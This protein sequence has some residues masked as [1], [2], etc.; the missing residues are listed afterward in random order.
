MKKCSKCQVVRPLSSFNKNRAKK[1][2]LQNY[3]RECSISR[4]QQWHSENSDK[5]SDPDRIR[6][7]NLAKHGLT[8]DEWDEINEAQSGKC[9]ICG[10]GGRMFVDHDHSSGL[11]RGIICEHC[12]RGLGAFCDNPEAMRAAIAY[13][14]SPPLADRQIFSK[15]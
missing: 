15:H 3:C 12:N 9:P 11:V 1:D 8:P 7:Y 4:A 14:A 5:R 10:Q 13:L 6:S 2:G